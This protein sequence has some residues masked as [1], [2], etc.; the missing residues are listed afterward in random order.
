MLTLFCNNSHFSSSQCA[1]LQEE[2]NAFLLLSADEVKRQES[3]QEYLGTYSMLYQKLEQLTI[4]CSERTKM[5]AEI[6]SEIEMKG[7][8]ARRAMRQIR[9]EVEDASCKCS[10]SL[11]QRKRELEVC[12][13]TEDLQAK[14]KEVVVKFSHILFSCLNEC[15]IF[16]V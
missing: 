7:F 15:F 3:A 1:E 12:L 10:R 4:E 8:E 14:Q 5:F 9:Q 2:I 11:Q 6:S 13:R 16:L